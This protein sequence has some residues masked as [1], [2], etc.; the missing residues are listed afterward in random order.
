MSSTQDAKDV[1]ALRALLGHA[2]WNPENGGNWTRIAEH[3]LASDW[4][5][6]REAAAATR[7]RAEAGKR[8][9]QDIEDAG[10][11]GFWEQDNGGGSSP[12]RIYGHWVDTD[13]AARI[14]RADS[15][16]PAPRGD[17]VGA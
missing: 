15:L 3:V 1:A 5:R 13:D 16:D 9:A 4:L 6:D 8:I 2:F 17:G 12:D 11:S 7:E 10:R 14:A